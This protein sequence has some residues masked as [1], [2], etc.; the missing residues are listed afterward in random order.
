[1]SHSLSFFEKQV[2]LVEHD[3]GGSGQIAKGPSV[4]MKKRG[5]G[6]R[7]EKGRGKISFS[8]GVGGVG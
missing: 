6:E 4:D 3:W 1:M 8:V 2:T 7:R 5:R